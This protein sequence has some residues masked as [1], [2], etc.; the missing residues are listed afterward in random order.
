MKRASTLWPISLCREILLLP[1]P[2]FEPWLETR[3]N[4]AEQCF[5]ITG[6]GTERR[7]APAMTS[8]AIAWPSTLSVF[9]YC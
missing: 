3:I 5:R 7:E 9:F 8:A 4:F 2:C 1:T 6:I